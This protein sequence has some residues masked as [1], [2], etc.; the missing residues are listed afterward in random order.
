MLPAEIRTRELN[1]NLFFSNFSGAPGISRQ[2]PRISRP[3]VWFP[4]V[5]RDIPNFLAPTRSRGRPPPKL[6]ISGLKSL[7]L[8]SFFVPEIIGIFGPNFCRKRSHHVM[9]ASC[10]LITANFGTPPPAPQTKFTTSRYCNRSDAVDF[11]S[12]SASRSENA[13]HHKG[14]FLQRTSR[15]ALHKSLVLVQSKALK[16]RD[17]HRGLLKYIAS[18]TCIARFGELSPQNIAF[19]PLTK[20]LQSLEDVTF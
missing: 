6:K 20:S 16:S 11:C 4:C 2:I 13:S 5:S 1:T 15:F 18:Q 3:K 17:S 10:R 9:D 7:G 19:R 14:D 8:C 12:K